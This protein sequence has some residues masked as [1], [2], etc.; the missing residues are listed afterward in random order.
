M[1]ISEPQ[2]KQQ[3]WNPSKET[4]LIL[5]R[6]EQWRANRSQME[7]SKIRVRLKGY[8]DVKKFNLFKFLVGIGGF[9]F[10]VL[11]IEPIGIKL[12]KDL[13]VTDH[14][15]SYKNLPRAFDGYR[16]LH[17]TDL[18]LEKL[19]GI[20]HEIIKRIENEKFDLLVFTGDYQDGYSE[21]VTEAMQ[22]L[23]EIVDSVRPRDGII[24]TL[25]NHD[26]HE[27]APIIEAMGVQ[28]LINESIRIDRGNES[29]HITGL[30]DVHYFY[31]EMSKQ[32]MEFPIEGWKL[33]LVHSPEAYEMAAENGYSLYLNGHTHGGQICLPGRIP[34]FTHSDVPRKYASGI[35][36]KDQLIGYSNRGAGT[37]TLPMRFFC[38]GEVAFFTLHCE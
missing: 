28:L 29:I 33:A 8:L 18:H 30:D 24:G 10:K 4:K 25:G 21:V 11:G 35:W 12:A 26:V 36:K 7:H 22:M 9:F 1:V 23:R 14:H 2:K 15:L 32:A 31:N 27:L 19:P 5:S 3:S 16:I 38:P 20:H 37:T 17:L 13:E 6:R 34:V